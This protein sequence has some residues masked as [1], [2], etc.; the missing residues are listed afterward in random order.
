MFGLALTAALLTPQDPAVTGPKF[1]WPPVREQL[2][3]YTVELDKQRSLSAELEQAVA[4]AREEV[5]L[6]RA[7]SPRQSVRVQIDVALRGGA[8][9]VEVSYVTRVLG[10]PKLRW[11]LEK[12]AADAALPALGNDRTDVWG[13]PDDKKTAPARVPRNAVERAF[14]RRFE[15]GRKGAAT[16]TAIGDLYGDHLLPVVWDQPL[17]CWIGQM[18]NVIEL[19][20]EAAI[21]GKTLIREASGKFPLGHRETRVELAFTKVS[22][23][24]F[25]FTYEMTVRQ[26]VAK[27]RDLREKV[28]KPWEWHFAISGEATY[29]AGEQAFERVREKVAAHPTGM[30]PETLARLRDEAF[31]G[32][33]EVTRK[34]ETKPGRRRRR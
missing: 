6:S 11:K 13:P 22:G 12:A 9:A 7:R 24:S 30:A 28:A 17:P 3:Q 18:A 10:K 16:P 4:D 32:T 14:D 34:R 20:G 26:L 8:D 2:L 33:I 31:T 23:D 5:G 21:E 25:T 27:T 1:A 15:R 19:A 29:D